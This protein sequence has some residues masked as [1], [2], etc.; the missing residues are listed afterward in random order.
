MSTSLSKFGY[1]TSDNVSIPGPRGPIGLTGLTGEKGE[2]G[3]KGDPGQDAIFPLDL[4]GE[5]I[6]GILSLTG[7]PNPIYSDQIDPIKINSTLDFLGDD[8]Y[9]SLINVTEISSGVG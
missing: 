1:S 7:A 4:G 2:K 6:A 3:D 5:S 9:S 8:G